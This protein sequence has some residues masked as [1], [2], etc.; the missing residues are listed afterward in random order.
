MGAVLSQAGAWLIEARK[1]KR[2]R[3]SR[4]D[5]DLRELYGA[6][7]EAGRVAVEII[8]APSTGYE[9]NAMGSLY[10]QIE[11]S[12]PTP[13]SEAAFD[14]W[15]STGRL[16]AAVLSKTEGVDSRIDDLTRRQREFLDAVRESLGMEPISTP[17]R[18]LH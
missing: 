7:I 11:I 1:Y 17:L 18:L 12:A 9:M 14:V 10:A 13:V 8:E 2:D 5:R 6:F 16:R 15:L 3:D 4:W